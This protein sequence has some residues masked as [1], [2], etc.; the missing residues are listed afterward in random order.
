MGSFKTD[1][2]STNGPHLHED[3]SYNLQSYAKL[4]FWNPLKRTEQNG[5]GIETSNDLSLNYGN[6][7]FHYIY[8]LASILNILILLG[9]LVLVLI[10]LCQALRVNAPAPSWAA[11]PRENYC[12]S[13]EAEASQHM[14][15]PWKLLLLMASQRSIIDTS[16]CPGN[17]SFILFYFHFTKIINFPLI[18]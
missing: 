17:V 5:S 12:D 3:L 2:L 11:S 10:Y 18:D 15:Y 6:G 14:L 4:M 7:S 16:A 8:I 9:S 13:Q 1:K